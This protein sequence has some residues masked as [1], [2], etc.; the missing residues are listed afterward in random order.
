MG[1]LANKIA[2]ITG[3]NSGIGYSTAK[4]FKENG[5]TVII[6]GRD[7]EKVKKATTELGVEGIVADV[8]NLKQLDSMVE[9][10]KNTHGFLDILFVNAGVFFGVPVGQNTEELFDMQMNI[11]FKGAVFTI[12]K[13]LPILKDGASIISLSTALAD[14][15]SGMPNTSIYTASKAAL[16][17]YIKVAMTELSS[18]KIRINTVSPGPIATPIFS[19]TG[20]TEEQINGFG[21][22]MQNRVPL[23][24]FGQ[25]EEVAKLVSFLASNESSY[26]NGAEI[27]I[28]GGIR[29]NPGLFG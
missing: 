29:I 21:A 16:N 9:K 13:L 5:A 23:K 4:E 11:N 26:I 10:V 2:L 25:P 27:T 20:M 24:R 22:A 12:E 8:Q 28:D 1:K 19:K 17:A 18:R 15:G 14:P 7:E 3:G 6:T